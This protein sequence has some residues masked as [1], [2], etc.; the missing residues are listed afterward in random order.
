[1]SKSFLQAISILKGVQQG[2]GLGAGAGAAP[3]KRHRNSSSLSKPAL[4]KPEEA[5]IHASPTLHSSSIPA[6]EDRDDSMDW[7]PSGPFTFHRWH[8]LV[9]R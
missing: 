7:P 5:V 1:M 9:E 6:D 4:L 3:R 8:V 2:S